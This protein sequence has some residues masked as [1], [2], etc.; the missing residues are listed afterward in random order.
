MRKADG[1]YDECGKAKAGP[2]RATYCVPLRMKALV[3]RLETSRVASHDWLR[4][5]TSCCSITRL[6]HRLDD[7]LLLYSGLRAS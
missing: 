7:C 2:G 5:L 4:I 1:G 6:H 3:D